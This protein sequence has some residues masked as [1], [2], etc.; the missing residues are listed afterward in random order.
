M[1]ETLNFIDGNN[2][3]DDLIVSFDTEGSPYSYY[4][5]DDWHL[6]SLGFDVSF[7]RLSGDFKKTVKYLVYKIIL[8]D[9][10]KSKKS[11]IKNIIEGAVIFE[12]CITGCNGLSYSFIDDNDNFRRILDEAKK[13]RLKFKTWKNNLIFLSHLNNAEIITREIKNHEELALYLSASGASVS[14]AVCIPE[15]IASKYYSEA[16]NV[17]E[18]YYPYRNEISSCYDDYVSEYLESSKRYKSNISARRYALKNVKQLPKNIDIQFDYSG[19]WLSWLRGAC[20]TVIAAFTGCRDGEIKSFDIYSYQE[21]KYAGMT[22]PVLHGLDTKPNAGGVA[23]HT[24]WVTIPSVKKAILLLWDAFSFAREKWREQADS[25][26]HPDERNA[27]LEKVNSL[28]VTLP[29]MRGHRPNAGK[30]SL[31]HSLN[32]FVKSIG[33]RATKDDVQEFD[34]LNP[35]RKGELKTGQILK[36]HPHAFRR[37][38][39]VYL[40]RNKLAS[41][42]DIKYQFKHMNIAMTSWYAN[43]ANIASYADM[44]IDQDLQDEIAGE[45]QNYMTDIFYH[46]YNEAETLAGHEGKRI[47]NLRVEGDTRIYLDREEIRKQVQDGRLS[48]VEH[49]GGYCTNPNCD[50]ICDMTTCQYKI[51]TKDKAKSLIKIREKLIVKYTEIESIG[52]DMPN[53]SSKLF[54]EIRAIE[55]VLSE[56]HLAYVAFNEKDTY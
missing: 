24:S 1:K 14:Q 15:S 2:T 56:H 3:N 10:L 52:L 51:V 31:A 47:K 22:V 25:I 29:Y 21:K 43:Q 16:L 20:Y 32:T 34:L 13:K 48:I 18:T 37:T 27:F 41:L 4:S 11:T 5:Y 44:M 39:A 33:Y 9:N 40:V 55:Q 46:L 45:N 36:V 53:V 50:R 6:W 54:Y 38:F 42:L 8:N 23:R 7:S 35:S 49:P 12:K 26:V 19:S 30:Q 28:F 17:I